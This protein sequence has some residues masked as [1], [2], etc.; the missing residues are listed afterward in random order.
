MS[1]F[2][3]A[4]TPKAIDATMI[5][6]SVGMITLLIFI[7]AKMPFIFLCSTNF[8]YFIML[9]SPLSKIIILIISYK[10][11]ITNN[12]IIAGNSKSS[13]YLQIIFT[14]T[15]SSVFCSPH[16]LIALREYIVSTIR[17][18][19]F[20][21]YSVSNRTAPRCRTFCTSPYNSF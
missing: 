11:T 9:N 3:H 2:P 5:R 16:R 10:F 4:V 21:F 20:K 14:E 12:F 17:T 8:L 15:N 1:F 6:V 19:R 18:A 13:V 7:I